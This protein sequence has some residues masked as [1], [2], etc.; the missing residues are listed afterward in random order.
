MCPAG[1]PWGLED[2]A[3]LLAPPFAIYFCTI[4]LFG[5]LLFF[6]W[7]L[8][9]RSCIPGIRSALGGPLALLLLGLTLSSPFSFL[10]QTRGVVDWEEWD[11]R[12]RKDLASLLGLGLGRIFPSSCGH[13]PVVASW[14]GL[15]TML[16]PVVG[17]LAH[18]TLPRL[19]GG[20]GTLPEATG[21]AGR[22]S[23]E[24]LTDQDTL[25]GKHRMAGA[26]ART[27]T[28]LSAVF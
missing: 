16:L 6:I 10:P 14:P 17:T 8:Q 24:S 3:A 11:C 18:R 25:R 12:T 26:R 5:L 28:R 21:L 27:P 1:E 2:R 22:L 20:L 13:W 7:G 15:R 23:E 9:C 4:L 19:E